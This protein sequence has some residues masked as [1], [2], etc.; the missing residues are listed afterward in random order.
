MNQKISSSIKILKNHKGQQIIWANIMKRIS[1][2]IIQ[3]TIIALGS[4][5][6]LYSYNKKLRWVDYFLHLP[7]WIIVVR[8]SGLYWNSVTIYVMKETIEISQQRSIS[9]WNES[10]QINV[11]GQQERYTIWC[12][13]KSCA[14]SLNSYSYI[15][16]LYVFSKLFD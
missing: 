8:P 12:C 4:S 16:F 14:L 1:A 2:A 5:I 9:A 10:I 7:F 6:F 15:A 11:L 3:P 13:A